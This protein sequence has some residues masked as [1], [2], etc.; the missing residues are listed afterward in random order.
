MRGGLDRLQK[1]MDA[2]TYNS[3]SVLNALIRST[4]VSGSSKGFT[5]TRVG[6]DRIDKNRY[7][8]FV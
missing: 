3:R 6:T 2:L 5:A 1:E 4:V 7:I 8:S